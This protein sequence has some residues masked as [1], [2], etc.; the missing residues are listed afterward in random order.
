MMSG[1][2]SWTCTMPTPV[3]FKVAMIVKV[4]TWTIRAQRVFLVN[5]DHGPIENPILDA[6]LLCIF[7]VLRANKRRCNEV[8]RTDEFQ[9]YSS[10]LRPKV[11]LTLNTH[12]NPNRLRSSFGGVNCHP[13]LRGAAA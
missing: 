13:C 9:Q 1:D 4:M 6:N 3:N 11:H 8:M 12:P 10:Q 5:F 2:P 7:M